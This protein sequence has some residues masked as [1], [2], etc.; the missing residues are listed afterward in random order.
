MVLQINTT[1]LRDWFFIIS[2]CFGLNGKLLQKNTP[3][4]IPQWCYFLKEVVEIS[5]PWKPNTENFSSSLNLMHNLQNCHV[6]FY[7]IAHILLTW[8]NTNTPSRILM[9]YTW[10]NLPLCLFC[11]FKVCNSSF[12]P[13]YY[14]NYG[15]HISK[16]KSDTMSLLLTVGIWLNTRLKL[17][18][19]LILNFGAKRKW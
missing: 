2:E 17:Q 1:V 14:P 9:L 4:G 16:E 8:I 13:Q 12:R 7:C 15:R 6:T 10:T 5:V 18:F 3:I 11:H 19:K